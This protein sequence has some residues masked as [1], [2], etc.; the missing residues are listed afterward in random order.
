MIFGAI[1]LVVL[2]VL[3]IQGLRAARDLT[4]AL[5]A[6]SMLLLLAVLVPGVGVEANGATRWIGVGLFQVQPSEI[7]KIAL[8]LYGAHLLAT[9]PKIADDLR[10][11]A[12]YLPRRA[13]SH[14]C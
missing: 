13:A 14:A 11:M 6:V 8:I 5:L 9:R 2:R 1:G 4:P 12:P 10:S 7:A 3:S